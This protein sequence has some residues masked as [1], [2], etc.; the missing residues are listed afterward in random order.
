MGVSIGLRV[1]AGRGAERVALPTY[2][3]QRQRYWL[4]LD[5]R[6]WGCGALPVWELPGI[7]C[8]VLWL[9][10]RR[11][12]AGCSLVVFRWSLIRGWPIMW[13]LVGVAAGDGVVGAGVACWW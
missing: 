13:C 9:G 10:W 11:A 5:R 4:E 3:F 12:T 7:R 1:F 2:A 6:R 8:W